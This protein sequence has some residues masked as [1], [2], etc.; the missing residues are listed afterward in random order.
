MRRRQRANGGAA[1]AAAAPLPALRASR[2]GQRPCGGGGWGRGPGG[3]GNWRRDAGAQLQLHCANRAPLALSAAGTG[4]CMSTRVCMWV[5]TSLHACRQACC[6]GS[7]STCVQKPQPHLLR[8][9]VKHHRSY[10]VLHSTTIRQ[11]GRQE[12]NVARTPQQPAPTHPQ[13]STPKP[14][15]AAGTGEAAATPAAAP[16]H[17]AGRLTPP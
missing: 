5:S 3:G 12:G 1:L 16:A 14:T 15:A 13:R 11:H 6:P 9:V 17:V 2:Q 10:R 7:H 8:R 4:V